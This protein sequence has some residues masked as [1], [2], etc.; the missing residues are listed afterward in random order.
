[1][2][3]HKF[4]I[5][6]KQK[7]DSPRRRKVLPPKEVLLK[8]G[9]SNTDTFADIGCGIG[10][11]TLPAAQ[12]LDETGKVYAV[13]VSQE[14]LEEVKKSAEENAFTNIELIKSEEY[15]L[16]LPDDSV[17]YCFSC[18]V[19]HEIKD[20]KHFIKELIR[21]VKKNGKLVIIEWNDHIADWG[22]SADHRL[23]SSVLQELIQAE[24]LQVDSPIDIGGYFYGLICR[25]D[26]NDETKTD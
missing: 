9:L 19:L 10:Y 6:H 17:S 11:F 14:M 7:L 16:P 26:Y 25:K 20:L 8:L 5:K 2:M 21:I 13:D 4:D 18:N 15:A 3:S 23:P 22:P 12:I 1:M 24:G